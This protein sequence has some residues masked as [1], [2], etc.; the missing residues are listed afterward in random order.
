MASL[1]TKNAIAT[2]SNMPTEP[3][4][5]IRDAIALA[6][7]CPDEAIKYMEHAVL[8]ITD[9]PIMIKQY[10]QAAK[11]INKYLDYIENTRYY[12][13]EEF[14]GQHVKPRRVE[15]LETVLDIEDWIA[16]EKFKR[17]LLNTENV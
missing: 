7:W 5:L 17:G 10:N 14:W 15:Y 8:R 3:S 4:R 9:S 16:M 6:K 11:E 1:L 12:N 2:R 13:Q